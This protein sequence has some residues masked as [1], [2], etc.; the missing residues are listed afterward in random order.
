VSDSGLS[1]LDPMGRPRMVDVSDKKVTR[2]YAIAA[3]YISLDEKCASAL[4]AAIS[5]PSRKGDPWSMARVGAIMAAKRTS[6][7]IPLAHPLALDAISIDHFWDPSRRH[8]WI[9]AEVRL[10]GRTGVEM[11][12]M[13]AVTGG[14]LAL[15]DMLKAAGHGMELGPVR[16]LSKAGGRHGIIEYSWPETPW[17]D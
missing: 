7:I 12:A 4:E 13:T 3:G 11:E 5:G 9:R 15:Y 16:L 8:A 17:V 6:D 10:E 2:R 1:H 14:L